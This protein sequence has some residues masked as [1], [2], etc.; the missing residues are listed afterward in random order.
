MLNGQLLFFNANGNPI[1][2]MGDEPIFSEL[3]PGSDALN[4]LNA[5]AASRHPQFIYRTMAG[6]ERGLDYQ[7]FAQL[8][9]IFADD[10]IVDV[11]SANSP[12]VGQV[13]TVVAP[14]DHSSIIRNQAPQLVIIDQIGLLQESESE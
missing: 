10:G 14:N 4:T 6:N 12:V 9:G 7:V 3:V 13:S 2:V 8:I 5:Q 11:E 1:D